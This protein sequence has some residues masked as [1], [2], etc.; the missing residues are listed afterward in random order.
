MTAPDA[1]TTTTLGD[2]IQN[3]TLPDGGQAQPPSKDERAQ[4]AKELAARGYEMLD[5]DADQDEADA[6]DC[7]N[8]HSRFP[9]LPPGEAKAKGNELFKQKK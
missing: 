5:E 8:P 4:M 1:P 2:F 7:E 3:S 9:T 6:E